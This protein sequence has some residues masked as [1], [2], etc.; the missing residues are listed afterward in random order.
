MSR[1]TWGILLKGVGVEGRHHTATAQVND[2]DQDLPDA[3]TAP[4]PRALVEPNDNSHPHHWA[5]GVRP[6]Y[7]NA[8]IAPSVRN[9]QRENIKAVHPFVSNQA[10]PGPT[11][12]LIAAATLASVQRRPSTMGVPLGVGD[13][14]TSQKLWVVWGGHRH[15][16]RPFSTCTTR[17]P[18]IPAN[19]PTSACERRSPCIDFTRYRQIS[20][21]YTRRSCGPGG[22]PRREIDKLLQ[23]SLHREIGEN[24]P[25]EG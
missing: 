15:G 9:Q 11:W 12:W 20:V 14:A 2:S 1:R 6:S 22:R 17:S 23:P 13:R 5:A 7:P 19:G 10:V 21:R 18:E 3:E 25:R 16:L 4:R 24:L 8:A